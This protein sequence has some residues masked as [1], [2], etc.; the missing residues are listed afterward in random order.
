MTTQNVNNNIMQDDNVIQFDV[1]K[2]LLF[3]CYIE[4]LIFL[5]KM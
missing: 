1:D 2:N 4:F 5:K 3:L